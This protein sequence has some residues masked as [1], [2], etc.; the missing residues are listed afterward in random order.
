MKECGVGMDRS[1]FVPDGQCGVW[2][3]PETHDF[4]FLLMLNNSADFILL[5]HSPL[6]TNE[7]FIVSVWSVNIS[8]VSV[9]KWVFIKVRHI[10]HCPVFT[11]YP[12]PQMQHIQQIWQ[13]WLI[14]SCLMTDVNLGLQFRE[15]EIKHQTLSICWWNLT[16]L[17]M[18][19]ATFKWTQNQ[20]IN[21]Q[22]LSD[23]S[24]RETMFKK[25]PILIWVILDNMII[26]TLIECH[27]DYKKHS[28]SFMIGILKVKSSGYLLVL[29]TVT[30]TAGG[31][32]Y[33]E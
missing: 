7:L 4:R 8:L 12:H 11:P 19:Y 14:N 24:L 3:S 25:E 17:F 16:A 21:T 2:F 1:G 23:I 32:V 22:L 29:R 13:I 26:K 9:I 6:H 30:V 20:E 18:I 27:I 10:T 31:T 33:W 28:W 15:N 5:R